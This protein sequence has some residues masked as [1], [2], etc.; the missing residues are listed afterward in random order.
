MC[1]MFKSFLMLKQVVPA[2]T[3]VFYGVSTANVNSAQ[4]EQNKYIWT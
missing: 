2:V 4:G 1:A 3:A